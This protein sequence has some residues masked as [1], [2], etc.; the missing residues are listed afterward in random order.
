MNYKYGSLWAE[1]GLAASFAQ[2]INRASLGGDDGIYT[3]L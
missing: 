2:T 3:G 1:P